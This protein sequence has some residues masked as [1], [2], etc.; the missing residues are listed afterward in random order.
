MSTMVLD[1]P[2]LQSLILAHKKKADCQDKRSFIH[3]E[4]QREARE[5]RKKRK[6]ESLYYSS[7]SDQDLGGKDVDCLFFS[8]FQL[9]MY[10]LA[11]TVK[12]CLE[13]GWQ[14]FF[15]SSFIFICVAGSFSFFV[16][17]FSQPKRQSR[18]VFDKE[19][20]VSFLYIQPARQRS[21]PSIEKR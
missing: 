10:V 7:W 1:H 14:F 11:F 17:L 2:P 16:F 19:K 5:K 6:R 3:Q 15:P 9:N 8:C 4:E 12:S 13:S 18:P 20:R 21:V